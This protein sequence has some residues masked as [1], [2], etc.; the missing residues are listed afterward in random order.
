LAVLYRIASAGT[1]F[2]GTEYVDPAAGFVSTRSRAEVQR[3]MQEAKAHGYTMPS[4]TPGDENTGAR[5]PLRPDYS[6]ASGGA[7]S[8][9][10][11][12]GSNLA[13]SSHASPSGQ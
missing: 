6:S 5:V 11:A 3:E 8:D 13:A 7:Y 10:K 9:S 4:R 12:Q 2:A 1:A